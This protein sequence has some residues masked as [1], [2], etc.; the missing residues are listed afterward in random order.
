[1]STDFFRLNIIPMAYYM[2]YYIILKS[3]T[4]N[5]PVFFKFNKGKLCNS[6]KCFF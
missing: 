3:I 1:M 6:Q 4:I 5:S 2:A